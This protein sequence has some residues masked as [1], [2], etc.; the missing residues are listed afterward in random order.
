MVDLTSFLEETQ[1]KFV[2]DRNSSIG[3]KFTIT[4]PEP[5]L[6]KKEM[7]GADKLSVLIT[8]IK[9]SDS[10]EYKVSMSSQNARR[11]AEKFGNDTAAWIGQQFIIEKQEYYEKFGR[12][13]FIY[14][15][16]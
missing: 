3:D 8:C 2:N 15:A 1:S 12:K 16:I 5:A 14:N 4:T 13:G 7:N 11:L 10:K 6:E 9:Q